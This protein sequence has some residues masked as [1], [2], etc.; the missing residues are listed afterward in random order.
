MQQ[1][2]DYLIDQTVT[3]ETGNFAF[4]DAPAGTFYI[5]IKFPAM[6]D[7]YKVAWQEPVTVDPQRIRFVTL[8][9]ENLV[10]P[11]SRRR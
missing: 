7:G 11:K 9:E 8:K 6:I 1:D 5:L 2:P 4:L 10:L 3:S